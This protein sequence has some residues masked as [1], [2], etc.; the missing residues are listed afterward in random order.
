MRAESPRTPRFVPADERIV[1]RVRPALPFI[2]PGPA[3]IWAP[4]LLM[5]GLWLVLRPLGAWLGGGAR[6][7]P[8]ATIGL[9]LLGVWALWAILEWWSRVYVLTERRIVVVA[10]FARQ[11]VG[12]VPLENVQHLTVS[13]SILERLLGLGTVGIATAGGDGPVVNWLAVSNPVAVLETIRRQADRAGRS[14]TRSSVPAIDAPAGPGAHAQPP[15]PPGRPLV[16]GLAGGI[17]AGKSEVARLLAEL[18]CVVV[19]SDVQ[20]RAALERPEVKE[21][22]RNWWGDR[23]LAPDGRVDRSAIA[24]IVFKD[25]AQRERLEGLIH[26][27]IKQ[28]RAELVARAASA[29]APGVVVDAP[30][31]FEAGVDAECDAVIFVEAPRE[32]RLRRVREARGWDE[33]ELARREASQMPLEEKRRRSSAVVVNDG[34]TVALRARVRDAFARLGSP[35][36]DA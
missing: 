25:P 27:L 5:L 13:R 33:A 19:D 12:D 35:E 16:I 1:L 10:G 28:R 2:P 29:S 15:R 23:V 26:P 21:T 6:L 20:A 32:V 14:G 31:L 24:S 30:L 11:V 34:D 18:G 8:L 36:R 17:G 4:P 3:W 22:L 7:A 9:I